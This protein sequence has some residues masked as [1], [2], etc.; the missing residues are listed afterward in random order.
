MMLQT[1]VRA[2]TVIMEAEA[3]ARCGAEYGERDQERTNTRNGYRERVLE[4]RMGMAE[5]R[6][7]KLRTGSY[8]PSFLEPRRR[9]EQAF[10]SVISE[11]Y[12]QTIFAQS[13]SEL[14]HEA[15]HKAVQ[16][17]RPKYPAAAAIVEEAEHDV[18]AYM[19][20]PEKHW[21][22]LHSTNPLERQNRE[23][24]RRTDVIGIFPNPASALRL[25]TMLL[26]EQN[27]E[28][29]VNKR[30]FSLESMA[31]MKSSPPTP[32]PSLEVAA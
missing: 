11:A 18:L 24:R 30:Y 16:L 14:A 2:L 10:V 28:W 9:W 26:I 1:L 27:D 4:T 20:F 29:A 13:S 31:L 6:I 5:L 21:M 32:M 23:I 19:N 3:N 15:L 22:Q 12:I 8:F 17:L 25:V 7:P